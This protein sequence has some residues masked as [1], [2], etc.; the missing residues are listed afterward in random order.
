MMPAIVRHGEARVAEL[1][2]HLD[3]TRRRAR[4]ARRNAWRSALSRLAG[5][6]GLALGFTAGLAWGVAWRRP[7][8]TTGRPR[9]LRRLFA[10]LARHAAAGALSTWA[11]QRRETA[12]DTGD[13]A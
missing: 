11:L 2:Q 4:T 13:S 12:A 5:P 1:E 6:D 7:L 10:S 3:L 9:P 8:A